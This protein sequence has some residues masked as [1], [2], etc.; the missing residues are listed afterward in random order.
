MSPSK[1][2]LPTIYSVLRSL[3]SRTSLRSRLLKEL[4]QQPNVCELYP[5][6]TPRPNST[7]SSMTTT[8]PE[9]EA[10]SRRGRWPFIGTAPTRVASS[11]WAT[12]SGTSATRTMSGR[13][14]RGGKSKGTVGTVSTA[15]TEDTVATSGTPGTASTFVDIVSTCT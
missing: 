1:F 5:L 11:T 14:V 12:V 13:G 9:P 7:E 15:I 6:P 3:H 2:H 8:G 10:S 4:E